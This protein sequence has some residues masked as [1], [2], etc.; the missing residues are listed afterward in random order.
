MDNKK[1][2][3]KTCRYVFIWSLLIGLIFT[4]P[5]LAQTNSLTGKIICIDPGHGGTAATD[6][7]RQGPTGER[8]EWVNLRV[9]LHLKTLL[10]DQGAV[11]VMTRTS[12]EAVPLTRRAE[13]AREHD[14]D[15]FLSIHHN[16]TADPQVN[17]PIIYFHGN[18]SENLAGARLGESLALS[19]RK[20]MYKEDVPVSIVSDYAIFAGAGASVL[21]ETYGIPAVLAEASFFTNPEE[22]HRLKDPAY[23]HQEAAAYLDALINY[24][25]API[26]DIYDKYSLVAEIQP[27][28]GLQ[29]AE[30]M[31]PLAKQWYQ[32][33][34]KGLAL[35]EGND[36]GSWE[37]AYEY[38]TR[39]A[40]SF[41][42]SHVA[43]DCHAKR[44][45]LLRKLGREE[46]AKE[47]EIR[48]NEFYF[49]IL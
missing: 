34:E 33:Y 37:Q 8:E 4:G 29:E 46:E 45:L 23:N 13:I 49:P 27:F 7:Y 9:A 15:V 44:F 2:D 28:R 18:A 38:F 6:S 1:Y 3:K 43:A 36:A 47:E 48:F 41:P 12:D 39:S 22:E 42:D 40:R 16:A 30:R 20:L 31:S 26:P 21:R 10:E 25:N 11:V 17:F 19:F 5:V 32:D 14:A 24:F 35:M